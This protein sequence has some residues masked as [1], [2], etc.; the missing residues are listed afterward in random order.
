MADNSRPSKTRKNDHGEAVPGGI[1]DADRQNDEEDD[2]IEWF[3]YTGQ[4]RNE[5]SH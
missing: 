4:S 2:E 3:I 1:N 5:I